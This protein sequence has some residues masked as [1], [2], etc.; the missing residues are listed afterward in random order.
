MENRF[1]MSGSQIIFGSK[2]FF[3]RGGWG[4]EVIVTINRFPSL[5][6]QILTHL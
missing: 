5:N 2:I 6:C 3:G 1:S 4:D